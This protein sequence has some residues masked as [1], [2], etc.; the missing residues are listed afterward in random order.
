MP[1]RRSLRLKDHKMLQQ[2]AEFSPDSEDIYE[3][4]LLNTLSSELRVLKMSVSMTLWPITI[5]KVEMMETENTP[6]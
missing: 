4:N 2:M 1:Q 6:N 5:G 3:E